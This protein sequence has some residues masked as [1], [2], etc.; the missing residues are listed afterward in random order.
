MPKAGG[1]LQAPEAAVSAGIKQSTWAEL[2]GG[3]DNAWDGV[4]LHMQDLLR[5]TALPS[6]VSPDSLHPI[7]GG[8]DHL[9]PEYQRLL[10]QVGVS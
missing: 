5:A 9:S 10:G 3:F 6:L 8:W 4:G 1:G 2:G 7:L